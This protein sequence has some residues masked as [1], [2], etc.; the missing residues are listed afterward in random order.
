MQYGLCHLSIV[1]LRAEPDDTSEQTSQ[2]LYGE[3]FKVLKKNQHWSHIRCGLDNYEGW[4]NNK[5]YTLI[6]KD[7]FESLKKSPKAY[8]SDLFA[9]VWKDRR[10]LFPIPIGSL[11]SSADTLLHQHEGKT[12]QGPTSKADIIDFA[13][14]FLNSP[15]QWGG[16]SPFGI[17]CSGFVQAVYRLCDITL[18]RD[19][20]QQAELGEPLGFIE[21][22]EAGDLVFFDNHEGR[23]VHVGILMDNHYIIHAFGQVRIDRL[24]HTGIYNAEQ[25]THTHKLRVIKKLI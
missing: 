3:F 20:C 11:V 8:A 18:P 1:P 25:N 23:I 21:E 17:D 10:I 16:K 13:L 6:D 12:T 2:L 22:S 4:I 7:C 24:D 9:F 14:L 19:A 5:Q 15:Y